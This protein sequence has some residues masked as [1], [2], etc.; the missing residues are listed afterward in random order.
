MDAYC[1]ARA[2]M[3]PRSADRGNDDDPKKPGTVGLLQWGRDLLIAEILWTA[4]S[5]TPASGFN[6]A[7]IC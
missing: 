4:P 1:Y 5:M 2:S 6:G 7:A 3:G